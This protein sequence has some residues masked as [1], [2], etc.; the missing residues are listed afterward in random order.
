MASYRKNKQRS[1]SHATKEYEF[2]Q[3]GNS[4]VS[5]EYTESSVN[6]NS[7]STQK[8][9]GK[10][11]FWIGITA[12][13]M[14]GTGIY[15]QSSVSTIKDVQSDGIGK[16]M[17]AGVR[18]VS[19]D[20]LADLV[21]RD[22]K[23]EMKQN[24]TTSRMLIWDFAAEDGDI[25]T[26][27]VDG[28]ILQT[29][30]NIMNSPVALDI[31]VPSVVEILGVKDGGGGITYAAKFPGAVQNNVYFNSAPVGSSNVYMITVQ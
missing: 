15:L 28:N 30:I 25:V 16:G 6:R 10:H 29:N 19:S 9:R 11:R 26:V 4:D 12:L 5:V 18:L 14:F 24:T 3:P 27:K 21:A 31:P 8:V 20:D 2:Q 17:K 13:I 1:K 7:S 23:I 22:F